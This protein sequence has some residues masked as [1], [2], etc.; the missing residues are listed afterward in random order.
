MKLA[1][2]AP[3]LE[4]EKRDELLRTLFNPKKFKEATTITS[5]KPKRPKVYSCPKCGH[6]DYS[7]AVFRHVKTADEKWKEWIEDWI[8][9]WIVKNKNTRPSKDFHNSF[10][11]IKKKSPLN[12]ANTPIVHEPLVTNDSHNSNSGIKKLHLGTGFSPRQEHL[13]AKIRDLQKFNSEIDIR[14]DTAPNEDKDSS[15][16]RDDD[17]QDDPLVFDMVSQ[18]DETILS[19]QIESEGISVDEED[20]AMRD[21]QDSSMLRDT[22]QNEP[23]EKG[24]LLQKHEYH[25]YLSTVDEED[26]AMRDDRDSSMLRDTTQNEPQVFDIAN[27][28][29]F[30]PQNMEEK[31]VSNDEEANTP[32]VDEPL[33]TNDSL[34]SLQINYSNLD[35]TQELI[36]IPDTL[37][38]EHMMIPNVNGSGAVSVCV[39]TDEAKKYFSSLSPMFRIRGRCEHF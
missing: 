36:M 24:D 7:L 9:N 12:E 28:P 17:A 33:V 27:S 35:E 1:D 32:I 34:R 25:R 21:D 22:T 15:L 38:Q 11:R 6:K 13:F 5:N 31:S 20:S 16:L 39:L 37:E 18:V 10:T 19:E 26:S 14:S 23:P 30:P 2:F 4:K 8:E 3:N 29:N